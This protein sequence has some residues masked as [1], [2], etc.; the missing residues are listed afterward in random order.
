LS[1][2][3]DVTLA[4][5]ED[6]YKDVTIDRQQ[7][8]PKVGL[9]WS[10][11]AATQVR[12]A[13]LRV[14]KRALIADETIEPTQVAGFNQF[15]DDPNGTQSDRAGIGIDHR[16]SPR[17][18][19]S[20]EASERNLKVPRLIGG[21][22]LEESQRE[23]LYRG[24]LTYLPWKILALNA[25]AQLEQLDIDP[26]DVDPTRPLSIYTTRLPL[27]ARLFPDERWSFFLQ[28]QNICKTRSVSARRPGMIFRCSMAACQCDCRSGAEQSRC[29]STTYSTRAFSIKI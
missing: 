8:S 14:M 6:W 22:A 15:F 17:L 1:P 10:P 16:F 23:Y 5:A 9:V 29:K 24:S 19:G 7:T 18:F 25:Q 12:A 21:Q 4:I 26:T 3:F 2:G 13:V 28:M 11:T 27:E 20:L